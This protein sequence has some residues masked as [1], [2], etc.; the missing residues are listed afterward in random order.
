MSPADYVSRTPQLL[1]SFD[2]AISRVK[3]LLVARYGNEASTLIQESRQ[4]YHHLIPQIPYLGQDNPL[5]DLFFFPASRHLGIYRVFREHGITVEEVGQLVYDIGGAEI[6]AIPSL[7]RRAIRILWFS[8]WFTD[9]LQKRAALSRERKYPGDYV[10]EF[11]PG[12]GKEFDYEFDYLECAALNFYRQQGA[13]ELVPYLCAIDKVASEL[14]GWGL[15][16]TATL[17][18]GGT[19]CDFQFKKGGETCVA[20]PQSLLQVGK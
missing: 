13:Q 6:K 16:R 7:V 2:R 15:R 14:L 18:E 19:R 12:N 10:V 17:A 20:V 5:L 4:E 3:P 11:V 1:R 8:R 9:R